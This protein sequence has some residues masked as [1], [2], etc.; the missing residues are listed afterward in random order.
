MYKKHEHV[1]SFDY[2]DLGYA[3]DK[4]D[5]NSLLVIAHLLEEIL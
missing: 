3:G 5:K 4:G 2:S 1:C